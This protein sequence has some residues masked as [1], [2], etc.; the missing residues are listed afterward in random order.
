[1]LSAAG[2]KNPRKS[3]GVIHDGTAKTPSTVLF[4]SSCSMEDV[5]VDS[6]S[7]LGG[8]SAESLNT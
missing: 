7:S 6:S 1:M 3:D 2:A 5:R 4:E 8:L